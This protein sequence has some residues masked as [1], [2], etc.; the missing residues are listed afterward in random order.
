MRN[1]ELKTR[2]LSTTVRTFSENGMFLQPVLDS[3]NAF[4]LQNKYFLSWH[5]LFG[6][7]N[8]MMKNTHVVQQTSNAQQMQNL[9]TY[10]QFL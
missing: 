2:P 6:D 10:L 8:K 3:P 7:G 1:R 5:N 4:G 9:I